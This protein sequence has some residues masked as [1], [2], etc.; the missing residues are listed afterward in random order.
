MHRKRPV[1]AAFLLVVSASL[2]TACSDD[3]TTTPTTAAGSAL[4]GT[5]YTEGPADEPVVVLDLLADGTWIYKWGQSPQ[6]ASFVGSGIY[7]VD[8]STVTWLGGECDAGGKGVYSYTLTNG[9]FTQEVENDPC[10]LRMLAF[11]GVVFT[12]TPPTRS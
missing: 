2:M 6:T 1:A 4:V 8:G 5:W 9:T 3:E 10:V 7:R 11:D 12:T